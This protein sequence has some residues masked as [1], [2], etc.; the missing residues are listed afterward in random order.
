MAQLHVYWTNEIT[1]SRDVNL[2]L[3]I[4][5]SRWYCRLYRKNCIQSIQCCI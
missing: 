3:C 2:E 4:G 1:T 5:Y